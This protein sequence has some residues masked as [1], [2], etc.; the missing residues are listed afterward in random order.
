[1]W[2]PEEQACFLAWTWPIHLVERQSTFSVPV[3]P[4]MLS[5]LLQN[6]TTISIQAIQAPCSSA[7][8]PW[9]KPISTDLFPSVRSSMPP[10]FSIS[11]PL[12]TIR[13]PAPLPAKPVLELHF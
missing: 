8:C 9:E 1:M 13:A 3:A 7:D 5:P 6:R 12:Q 2:L 10:T 4:P 11:R